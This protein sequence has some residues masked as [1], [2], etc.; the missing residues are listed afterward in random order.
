M[1]AAFPV[2]A[3]FVDSCIGTK[4]VPVLLL[5]LMIVAMIVGAVFQLAAFL[6]VDSDGI[7]VSCLGRVWRSASFDEIERISQRAQ[8]WNP[9]RWVVIHG[10]RGGRIEIPAFFA[11]DADEMER[12]LRN[13][14]LAWRERP[15]SLHVVSP[16]PVADVAALQRGERS[17]E[18]WI[19]HLRKIGDGAVLREASPPRELLWRLAESAEVT[20]AT[21]LA[22]LV[23]LDGAAATAGDRKRVGELG[24]ALVQ[25][26]EYA[27][28]LGALAT[29]LRHTRPLKDP[30]PS[31][32]R[33]PS[34]RRCSRRPTRLLRCPSK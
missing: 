32:R 14:L 7:A 30:A 28:S 25:S 10:K 26:D 1:F 11:A 12:T 9:S 20:P 21:R 23:A 4:A 15:P 5:P 29:A 18:E 16:E 8:F 13:A 3:A 33:G 2:A 31:R 27:H 24:D 22:A 17:V 34:S 19:T 6:D